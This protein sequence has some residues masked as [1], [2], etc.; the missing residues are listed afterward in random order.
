MMPVRLVVYLL[1]R[2]MQSSEYKRLTDPLTIFL[3]Y[4]TTVQKAQN[5]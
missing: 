1:A 3:H 2:E 5:G 4:V